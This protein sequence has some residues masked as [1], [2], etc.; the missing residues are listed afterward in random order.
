MKY[1]GLALMFVPLWFVWTFIYTMLMA[2][3][4]VGKD[5]KH[6]KQEIKELVDQGLVVGFLI[7]LFLYGVIFLFL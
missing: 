7:T 5:T 6:K 4:I 2:R 3:V 1:V